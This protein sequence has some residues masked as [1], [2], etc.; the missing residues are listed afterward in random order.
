MITTFLHETIRASLCVAFPRRFRD[1]IPGSKTGQNWSKT[2]SK[3]GPILDLFFLRFRKV[4][5]SSCGVIWAISRPSWGLGKRKSGYCLLVFEPSSFWLRGALHG[6]SRRLLAPLGP[7]LVPKQ[8][9]KVV[10]KVL[11]SGSERGP[12]TD[13]KIYH[14]LIRFWVRFGVSNPRSRDPVFHGLG[15]KNLDLV[16]VFDTFRG[17]WLFRRFSLFFRL[18]KR[19]S[20]FCIRFYM[21]SRPSAPLQKH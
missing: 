11:K 17:H 15:P 6:S 14:F 13:P 1:P 9:P 12:K 10:K 2:V 16:L 20:S 5:W 8:A 18:T 19:T 4:F 7:L 3:L 21:I